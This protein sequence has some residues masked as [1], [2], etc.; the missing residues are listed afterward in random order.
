[1]NINKIINTINQIFKKTSN[2]KV[3][4]RKIY[5][6]FFE[7]KNYIL[8]EKNLQWIKSNLV[9]FED[10]AKQLDPN[11]WEETKQVSENLANHSEQIFQKLDVDLGG[12]GFYPFLYFI[13]RYTQPNIIVETGVAA[14]FSSSAFLTAIDSNGKGTLYSSDFPYF[15]L[16]SPEKYIGIVVEKS[17]KKYWHL[18]IDGDE[19]NLPKIL[20]KID[21]IDIFHYDS[22]K[23]YSGRKMAMSLIKNKLSDQGIILMDDI[24]DNCFFYDYIQEYNPSHWCVF[25]F[26]GK[27]I[28]MVGKINKNN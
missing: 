18:Y 4:S 23:S 16:P 22:D 24:Q 9:I 19:I 8:P 27:Y 15:R 20:N 13:T 6:R 3:I 1:M 2:F 28:G 7:P 25:E 14:G 26:K 5:K 12:G 10:L 17:F 11:L 21:K